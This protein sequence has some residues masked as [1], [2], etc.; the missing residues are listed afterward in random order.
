MGSLAVQELAGTLVWRVGYRPQLWAWVG[1][2]CASEGRFPGRWDDAEGNFRTVYA[3][4]SLLGCLLEL[5]AD[6]R[7][8]PLLDVDLGQVVEDPED[9]AAFPTVSAG[10]VDPSWLAPRVGATGRLTG[11]FCAVTDARSM[12]VLHPLF[13]GQSL[14]LGLKDFDAAALKDARA[15]ELTQQLASHLVCVHH[16][17]RCGVPFPTR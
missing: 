15:R 10:V 16:P 17:G 8:D 13:V 11:R 1:W 14:R 5:L 3:G 4:S 6:F 9:A 7:A 2:E 12:A